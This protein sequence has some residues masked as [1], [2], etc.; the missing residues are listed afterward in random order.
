MILSRPDILKYLEEKR[1]IIE[2]EVSND[3]IAQVSIDL[4]LGRKFSQF[5]EKPKYISAIR[6][7]PSLWSAPGLWDHNE[8]DTFKLA[9]G[10]FV[11]TQ[12]L[13]VVHIPHDLV[14]LV[15]GRSSWAR[16]GITIHVTA[17]KID[18]GFNGPITLEMANFGCVPVEL[19]AGEDKPA[20]LMLMRITTPL[21]DP[22][23]YGTGPNDTFQNQKDPIPYKPKK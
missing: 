22:E 6:V 10:G 11:L 5:K 2:P 18:P 19:V 12:T 15:E 3:R 8:A 7:D 20:Q 17:P 16:V 23:L 1:L 9:P 21:A 13:E 14:G 4:R